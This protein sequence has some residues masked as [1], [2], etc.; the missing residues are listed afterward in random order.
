[1]LN[2]I[3]VLG[4]YLCCCHL[5]SA[6][7]VRSFKNKDLLKVSPFRSSKYRKM[8]NMRTGTEIVNPCITSGGSVADEFSEKSYVKNRAYLT[9]PFVL[10]AIA[11]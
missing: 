6:R 4:K 7:C 9:S 2:L 8:G 3:E 1:M 11:L 5:L 10:D